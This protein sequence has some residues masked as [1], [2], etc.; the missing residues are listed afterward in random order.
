MMT[1][2]KMKVDRHS[3]EVMY[4]S[5]VLPSMEYA[6]AVWGGTYDSDLC[7]LESIHVDAMRLIVGATARSNIV[8]V[9]NEMGSVNFQNRIND[10]A[11]VMLFKIQKGY[12]PGYLTHILDSFNGQRNYN[13][14]N[15]Q[16]KVPKCRLETYK[17]SFF[18]RSISLWNNLSEEVQSVDSVDVFKSNL[19]SKFNELLPLYYYGNRWPSVHHA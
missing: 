7:K 17:K 11:L 13:L 10:I 8:N 5:F 1:P 2:L 4:K 16:I 14:R 15:S 6:I 12:A 3:L 19:H 9:L 18:P